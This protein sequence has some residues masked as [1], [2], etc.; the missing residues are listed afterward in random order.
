MRW[1][2]DE[3]ELFCDDFLAILIYDSIICFLASDS[4]SKFCLDQSFMAASC[5]KTNLI[6]AVVVRCCHFA[7]SPCSCLKDKFPHKYAMFIILYMC[8]W[9]VSRRMGRHLATTIQRVIAIFA[10]SIDKIWIF[11]ASC[12]LFWWFCTSIGDLLIVVKYFEANISKDYIIFCF[13][14]VRFI[15]MWL[16]AWFWIYTIYL[17]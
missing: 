10:A 3:N 6:D 12:A 7:S 11:I 9:D 4:P 17:F 13:Y 8:I 2:L 16:R 14:L 15:W 5:L 1:K